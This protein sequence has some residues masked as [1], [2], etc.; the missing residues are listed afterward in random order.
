MFALSH[1]LTAV[2]VALRVRVIG[3]S[4][5]SLPALRFTRA[6]NSQYVSLGF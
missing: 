2:A 6:S 3:G 5:S 1:A 4:F